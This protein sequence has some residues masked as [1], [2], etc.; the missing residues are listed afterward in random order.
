MLN[1]SNPTDSFSF[2]N[3]ARIPYYQSGYSGE[4]NKMALR[5]IEM[6]LPEDIGKYAYEY[7]RD[8]QEHSLM[9]LWYH[10]LAEGEILVKMLV[11]VGEAEAVLDLIANN[12]GSVDGF[13]A[14]L[15]PVAA[16]LPRQEPVAEKQDDEEIAESEADKE[17]KR[18]RISRE[19]LYVNIGDAARLSKAYIAMVILSAI[20][21]TLGVLHNNVAVVIGAMVIAPLLGPNAALSLATT[22]GD[23]DLARTALKASGVGIT[24]SVL[25]SVVIGLLLQVDPTIHEIASRIQVGLSDIAIALAA[26]GAGTLAFTSGVPA[27]LVG[28]MVAVALLPPLVTSGLLIG[29]GFFHLAWGALLLFITNLICINLSGVVFFLFQGIRPRIWWE[30]DRAKKATRNAILIWIV[31]L[32]A[33]ILVIVFSQKN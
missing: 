33:L 9:G 15:I 3:L 13:R 26:G 24:L 8:Q 4:D 27:V 2:L 10:N 5:V 20:V 19:E 14:V 25:L 28:V 23:G 6:V 12:Y 22:L 17:R 31:L 1:F 30:A 7:L 18:E 21:A 16:S 32:C 29:S 11:S